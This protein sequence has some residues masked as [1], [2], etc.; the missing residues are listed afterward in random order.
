VSPRPQ[1]SYQKASKS[2]WNIIQFTKYVQKKDLTKTTVLAMFS[3]HPTTD[4]S[5]ISSPKLTKKHTSEP[6]LQISH[7]KPKKKQS[8]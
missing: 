1:E 7:P 4:P 2:Q 5:L 3:A 8:R 6:T